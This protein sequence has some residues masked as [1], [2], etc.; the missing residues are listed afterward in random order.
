MGFMKIMQAQNIDKNDISKHLNRLYEVRN[1]RNENVIRTS[2]KEVE[3][4]ASTENANTMPF[5]IKCVE[6]SGIEARDI[7]L[8]PI[9]SS[10]SVLTP[11]E[12]DLGV[13][14]VD[15]GGGTTDLA[16]WKDGS[17]A[18]SQII[19]VGGNH[20]TNDLAVALKIPHN[21]AERIKVNHGSVLPEQVNQSAHI[22]VNGLSNTRQRE[23]K[24]G[25]VA[26]VLGARAEELFTIIQD[27]LKEKNLFELINGGYIITGWISVPS[28]GKDL[29][30]IKTMNGL[31]FLLQRHHLILRFENHNFLG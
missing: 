21:E 9:A 26:E 29:V 23:V 22:T 3:E 17:L 4:V 31:L 19:P 11:E 27:I 14:L 30:L 5:I 28:Q 20:F 15:I 2:L 6:A 25:Q 10:R 7:V 16:V 13:V 18:H 24:V 12:K 1:N 8:Q